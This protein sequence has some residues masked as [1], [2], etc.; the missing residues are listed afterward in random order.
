MFNFPK[1]ELNTSGSIPIFDI[2]EKLYK[3]FYEKEKKFE[4]VYEGNF[5]DNRNDDE[6]KIEKN[7]EKD[8]QGDQF[9]ENNN[10]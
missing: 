3:F 7:S 10:K 8:F 1:K 4:K 2:M 9:L 6:K 5:T